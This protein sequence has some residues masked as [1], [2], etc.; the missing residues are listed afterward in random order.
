MN[1]S[2]LIDAIA[3]DADIT[4]VEAKKALESFISN[5]SSTLKKKDGKVSLVGFG[6]FSVAERAARQGINP[7][8]KKPI[9]IAAK[10]VAKFKA[11]SELAEAVNGKKK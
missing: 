1:K 10:K 9:K 5:V 2:E 3:K 6:T 8:T 11:G 4:K 7:S